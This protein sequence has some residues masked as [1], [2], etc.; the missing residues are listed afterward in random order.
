VQTPLPASVRAQRGEELCAA[1]E[2]TRTGPQDQQQ[3]ER[4][5]PTVRTETRCDAMAT[6]MTLLLLLMLMLML[7]R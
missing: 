3:L 4:L 1:T 5:E 7:T 2:S 6:M